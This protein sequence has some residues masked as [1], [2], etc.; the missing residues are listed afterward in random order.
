MPFLP[1]QLSRPLLHENDSSWPLVYR[2]PPLSWAGT[3]ILRAIRPWHTGSV[4]F[5]W[6]SRAWWR[7]QPHRGQLAQRRQCKSE[8]TVRPHDMRTPQLEGHQPRAQTTAGSKNPALQLQR[9]PQGGG[10]LVPAQEHP[11]W[12][13]CTE[14][15]EKLGCLKPVYSWQS[16]TAAMGN[17]YAME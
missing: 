17:Q 2:E 16:V 3:S 4:S 7:G 12:F 6:V 8:V 5:P 11:C 1:S 13:W 9:G 10:H 14:M 15:W